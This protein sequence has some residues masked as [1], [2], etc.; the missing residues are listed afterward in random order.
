VGLVALSNLQD[1]GF[2]GAVREGRRALDAAGAIAP[3]EWRPTPAELA[4]RDATMALRRVWDDA[5]AADLATFLP[6]LRSN[7]ASDLRD[8]GDCHVTK[9]AADGPLRVRIEAECERGGQA[10]RLLLDGDGRIQEIHRDNTFPPDPRLLAAARSL[11]GMVARWDE[12]S[13]G[14]LL[15]PG[16]ERAAMKAAFSDAA[17]VHR[18]C[19]VDHVDPR[20]DKTHGRLELACKQGRPLELVAVMNESGRL[21]S[22]TLVPVDAER[23]VRYRT[24]MESAAA[25]S[26]HLEAPPIGAVKVLAAVVEALAN[27]APAGYR[28]VYRTNAEGEHVVA[29]IWP[30]EPS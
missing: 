17:A 4:A 23:T 8:H 26:R 27:G 16:V 11:A 19:A 13:V 22:V 18:S 21:T 12:E 1:G 2:D 9:T 6:E 20:G 30:P 29:I 28:V 7:L 10:L 25:P 3:R 24:A 15:A 14:A 5:F